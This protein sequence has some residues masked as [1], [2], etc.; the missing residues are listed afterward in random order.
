MTACTAAHQAP[1]SVGF[2]RQGHWSGLPFVD[3]PFSA[4]FLRGGN[5]D[6]QIDSSDVHAQSKPLVRTQW[7]SATQEKEFQKKSDLLTFWPW[8]FCFQYCVRSEIFIFKP[9]SQFFFFFLMA[10]LEANIAPYCM[11]SVLV[12]TVLLLL[13]HMLLNVSAYS[14]TI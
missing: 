10:I 5:L 6:T 11:S 1:L 4:V 13:Y 2:S 8:N 9:S 14:H 3:I 12:Q 7:L